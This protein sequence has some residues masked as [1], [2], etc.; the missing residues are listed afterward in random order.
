[1]DR[2]EDYLDMLA[3]A[4][5]IQK[6]IADILEAKAYEAEK[7]RA[8]IC[9]H[10]LDA[11][12]GTGEELCKQSIELHESV[13]EILEGITRMEQGLSK[14]LNVLIG[15]QDGGLSAG[16]FDFFGNGGGS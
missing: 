15:Q 9:S 7:A 16:G 14:N 10:L 4:S 2:S 5:K 8:F 11:R 1:M 13:V 3:S 6:H 12:Y